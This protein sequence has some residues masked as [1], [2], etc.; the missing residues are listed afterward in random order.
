VNA[1]LRRVG[2]VV[3]VLFALLFV[4]LN[5][6]QG[7]K[8]KDY[9][10]SDYNRRTQLAQY[11]RQRGSVSIGGGQFVLAQ[12][13]ATND[14]LKYQRGYPAGGAYAHVLGYKPV[15]I[16]SAGVEK[17][18]DAYLAGEADAQWNDRIAAMFTGKTAH[19]G[20][21][22]LTLSR[23]AQERAFTE[24]ANN[25]TRTRKG[26]VV[27]LDPRTGAVLAAVSTP[28]YDPNPLASH[29]TEAAQKLYTQLNADPNKPMLNRA[30]A[31]RYP[32]GSTFKVVVS[33]AALA[34]GANPETVLEG[35]ARY[36]V[37]ETTNDITNAPGVTCPQ[38]ITLKQS[39][40]VS[41][42]TAFSRLGVDQLG[43]EKV[44]DMAKAF[45]FESVPEFERDDKN[46][47]G[48]VSSQTGP[49]TGPDGRVDRPVL[50]QSCIGQSSVAMT[51][52][53]GAL[54]AATV[55]NGGKQ[56]RPHIVDRL[57]G[58]DADTDY[59]AVRKD[60]R[61]VSDDV[62]R[63]LR[64]MMVNVV[65]NGTGRNARIAGFDVG[66][67]TGTA[68][69][70]E[71]QNDH[72]WFIGF[73]MKNDEP[74]AAVAVFLENAGSGGSAEATRIAGTVMKAVIDERGVK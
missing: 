62:A 9:R 20:N 51:P 65:T 29:D 58:A 64:S 49:M 15:Y 23:A 38:Q 41:C 21:V 60:R 2:V 47:M 34:N 13:T 46:T 68:E 10:T 6:V 16:G 45:G 26:A 39:L 35:G 73:V 55:A 32:P 12:S 53:Q 71:G 14:V 1:P 67:K 54:I 28:T 50:A 11:D 17:M 4:N 3:L 40:T 52:L 57:L 43:H 66:G 37:P 69:N 31:E 7:I 8:A 42:N 63:D 27:A 5:W 70:G 48:V 72:G 19:G 18:E 33:A 44:K 30:F 22:Y 25:R 61:V 59:T 56:P 24:L 36:D 74:V